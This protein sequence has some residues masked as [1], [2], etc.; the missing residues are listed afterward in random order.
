MTDSN[1]QENKKFK[2]DLGDYELVSTQ[3]GSYTLHSEYFNESCHSLSGAV[4]ETLFNYINGCELPDKLNQNEL[5]IFETGFGLGIGYKTTTEFLETSSFEGKLTFVSTELDSE[6]VNFA[7]TNT[8]LSQ[9]SN[10]P[11]FKELAF[12]NSPVPHFK[13][14]KNGH[15]LIILIGDARK[16][17]PVAL[18][19]GLLPKF[20]AIYQ[21]A[22]SPKRN[23]FL[24]TV[25]WFETLK[26]ISDKTVVLS[27]YSS[28]NSIRKSMIES[29]W[30]VQNR[31]GFGTKRTCTRA[32]LTGKTDEEVKLSLGRSPAASLR[33]KDI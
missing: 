16:T 8:E 14:S 25:E 12:N 22:F 21:D 7:K 9:S 10:Y 1:N 6:L 20:H 15:I 29:E 23:P 32:K 27:T 5:S 26:S 4:E 17:T 30:L 18:D 33:D 24:W 13:A 2:G 3:D 19:R 31:K 11:K 28:S